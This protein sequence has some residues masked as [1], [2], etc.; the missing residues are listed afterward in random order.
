MKCEMCVE[1]LEIK[2]NIDFVSK[3]LEVDRKVVGTA[4]SKDCQSRGREHVLIA[5]ISR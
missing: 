3:V 1:H 4:E 2:K 5:V